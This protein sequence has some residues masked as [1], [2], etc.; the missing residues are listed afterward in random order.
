MLERSPS[1]FLN[2]IK[3]STNSL[4]S[5]DLSTLAFLT[6]SGASTR[7]SAGACK[8]SHR[9]SSLRVGPAEPTP[10]PT[11]CSYYI[12]SDEKL[13]ALPFVAALPEISSIATEILDT[14]AGTLAAQSQVAC[15]DL[16]YRVQLIGNT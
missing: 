10:N 3:S 12:A 4:V 15:V 16:I 7:P 6:L 11:S 1:I 8:A 5:E 9:Q 13:Y 14:P 2:R